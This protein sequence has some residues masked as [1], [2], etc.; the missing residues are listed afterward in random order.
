MLKSYEAILERN[1]SVRWLT[2]APPRHATETRIIIVMEE[3]H[4]LLPVS[5]SSSREV[6]RRTRG[7]WGRG[8]TIEEVDAEIRQMRSEWEREWN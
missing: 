7:A 6:L 5:P 8:K 4:S 1:Q 2:P 3:D